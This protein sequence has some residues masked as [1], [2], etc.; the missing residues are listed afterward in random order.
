M[1]TSVLVLKKFPQPDKWS[2][3]QENELNFLREMAKKAVVYWV[4]KKSKILGRF[5]IMI[6]SQGDSGIDFCT[7]NW[8]AFILH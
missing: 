5:D 2:P 3:A 6:A 7:L 1:H 4:G 8:A